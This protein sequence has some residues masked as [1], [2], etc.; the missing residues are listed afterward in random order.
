MKL[1]PCRK[2]GKELVERYFFAVCDACGEIGLIVP[3][4]KREGENHAK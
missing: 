3:A 4:R 2:C 1:P